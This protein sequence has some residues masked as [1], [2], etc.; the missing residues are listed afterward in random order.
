ML[1]GLL[2]LT[3]LLAL[4]ASAHG[5]STRLT[6]NEKDAKWAL[7]T[8]YGA[9]LG[10]VRVDCRTEAEVCR[11]QWR[12]RD[13]PSWAALTCTARITLWGGRKGVMAMD[14]PPTC[15]RYQPWTGQRIYVG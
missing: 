7:E 11:N 10:T 13:R 8:F 6:E 15:W 2:A 3:V 9:R 14:F 1:R 4:P 12:T 5:W